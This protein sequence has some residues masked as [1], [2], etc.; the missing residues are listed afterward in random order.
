VPAAERRDATTDQRGA[1]CPQGHTR[2][3]GQGGV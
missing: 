3:R 1:R 2:G